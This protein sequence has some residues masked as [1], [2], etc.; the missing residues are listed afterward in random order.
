MSAKEWYNTGEQ[1]SIDA[2]S[3]F[4]KKEGNG[5]PLICIHGFPTSSWDFEPMWNQ[6][7]QHFLVIA[8]DL[9]GLGKSSKNYAEIS[10]KLQADVIEKI[11]LEFKITK[12]HILAH[13]LGDTVA[14]ELIARVK[15]GTSPIRWESCIFLNGGL[16]PETHRPRFIQKLLI[17]SFGPIVAKLSSFKTFRENMLRIFSAQHPPSEDFLNDSWEILIED[18][19]RRA[20]PRVIRYMEERKQ[21]RE[22]WVA[23]LVEKTIPIRLINGIVDP[24]SGEHAAKRY[25]ELVSEADI[26]WVED[27]GH[28]PHVETPKKVLKAIFEFHNFK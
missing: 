13:D 22:R 1:L 25:E 16:F 8:P 2:L 10:V 6:L 28:Y 17:S 14:Q 18:N 20:L 26:I 23:P 19:G 5:F 11:L 7:I 24:I 3:V 9:I 4:V 21:F 15:E 27:A 12:A